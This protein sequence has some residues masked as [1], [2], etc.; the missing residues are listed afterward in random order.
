MSI[1][2]NYLIL[3]YNVC[4]QGGA[5]LLVLR[6]A[7][8]LKEKGYNVKIVVAYDNGN[9]L[10]KEEF[11]G[12]EIILIRDF[13]N[14]LCLQ[15]YS[16]IASKI[17]E[18]SKIIDPQ[19]DGISY[20]ESHT[21]PTCVWGEVLADKF[22]AKHMTYLLA[23]LHFSDLKFYYDRKILLRKLRCRE[24][25]GVSASSIE[26]IF[27]KKYKKFSDQYINV[28]FDR[29]ELM[30]QS[31]PILNLHKEPDTFVIGTVTRLDKTYVEPLIEDSILLAKKYPFQKFLLLIAGGSPNSDRQQYLFNKYTTENIGVDNLSIRWTGYISKLGKDIFKFLDVFVGMGT[32]SIN[33]IS[34]ECLTLNIDPFADMCSGFFGTDTSN[35]AYS[36]RGGLYKIIDKLEEAYLMSDTNRGVYRSN[37]LALFDKEFDMIV[38]EKK[39]D[40]FFNDMVPYHKNRHKFIPIIYELNRILYNLLKTIKHKFLIN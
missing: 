2:E 35:F 20:I 24:F 34:Q 37:G 36:D 26:I 10:L 18:V 14:T 12:F 3:T 25:F 8:Y 17:L 11:K 23:E 40:R 27:G 31:L 39:Q 28:G 30:E 29:S 1:R 6:R 9:F 38:C 32:A 19:N 33:S 4:N 15:P 21:V 5:Q 7:K 16:K 13:S 22:Q